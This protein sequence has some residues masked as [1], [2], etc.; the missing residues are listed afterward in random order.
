MSW[1]SPDPLAHVLLVQEQV[2]KAL[3]GFCLGGDLA[4]S[5]EDILLAPEHPAYVYWTRQ[6]AQGRAR[7]GPVS[8]VE[9]LSMQ[10]MVASHASCEPGVLEWHAGGP[11]RRSPLSIN[12]TRRCELSSRPVSRKYRG[13]VVIAS[14]GCTCGCCC[15]TSPA[16]GRT[17]RTGSL[18]GTRQRPLCIRQ[19]LLLLPRP[20]HGPW[21]RRWSAAGP[22]SWSRRCLWGIVCG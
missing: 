1:G 9:L 3:K 11:C 22:R 12:P 18:R 13:F 10:G 4:L 21:Y 2:A 8:G 16:I 5:V 20:F 17:G 6:Q 19:C 14:G 15:P 7:Q